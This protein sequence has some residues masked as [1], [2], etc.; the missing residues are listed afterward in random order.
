MHVPWSIRYAL[1]AFVT[2]DKQLLRGSL[3]IQERFNGFSVV[4]PAAELEV[5]RR[6]LAR[7]RTRAAVAH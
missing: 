4:T 6:L 3:T 1:D 2:E 5:V 7:A